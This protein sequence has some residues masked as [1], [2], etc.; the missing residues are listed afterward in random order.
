MKKKAKGSITVFLSLIMLLI[1]S[2]VCTVIEISRISSAYAR[3]NEI[4][5]MA[6][7]STFSSYARE[8]F[9]DYGIMVLWKNDTQLLND[10]TKYVDK[11]SNYKKDFKYNIYDILG[12][13]NANSKV[14]TVKNVMDNGGEIIYDQ[15]CDYM[16]NAIAQD[17]IDKLMK[18]SNALS[19]NE[20]IEQ[21][22]KSLEVCSDKLKD[23]EVNVK[24]IFDD[25]N[26]I[27]QCPYNPK[28]VIQNMKDRLNE[29]KSIEPTDDYNRQVRD[30]LFDMYIIEYRKY[31]EWKNTLDNYLQDILINSDKYFENL[32]LAKDYVDDMDTK[33]AKEKANYQNE[34]YSIMK[35]EITDLKQEVFNSDKDNY[36]IENNKKLTLE[37]K[38]IVDEISNSMSP[39]LE[40]TDELDYSYNKLSNYENADILIEDSYKAIYLAEEKIINYNFNLSVNYS[41]GDAT[42]KK[43]EVVDFVKKLKKDGV[44][45]YVVNGDISDKT[46]DKGKLSSDTY[47]DTEY[48][49]K[50][51]GRDKELLR[52]ILVGQYIFDKFNDYISGEK[53][54]QLNY[55]IEYILFG[56]GCDRDNLKE[57][58]NKIILLREGFNFLFLLKDSTKR[59]EAYELALTI[60]GY[61][62]MP[63]IVRLTQF[64]IMAAW[65]YAESVVDAKNLLEGEKVSLIK[66]ADEWN[67][68]LSNIKSL[69]S[70]NNK[71]KVES[72][73]TYE[74]YLRY[75]LIS[76]DKYTQVI[77]MLD[78]MELNIQ[79]KYNV[80]FQMKQCIVQATVYT[81]YKVKR[82]FSDIGFTRQII[83]GKEDEF[84]VKV[85]QTSGY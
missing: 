15:I 75:L 54:N 36:N 28:E 73:L 14:E 19:Q 9:E 85:K 68:S 41:I 46:I 83:R 50:N 23:M 7:D 71:N 58:I 47:K 17:V 27:K 62:G 59:N 35:E 20:D 51:Y 72:G 81:E 38:E 21:F 74:D 26:T 18:N 25:I 64:L 70:D 45:G 69:K 37:Q 40:R 57:C 31:K 3:C 6:L 8:I 42:K 44:M 1:F 34:L 11:N 2:L 63:A 4:T 52:K 61:T 65:S 82:L 24:N 30:N 78:L 48:K 56:N 29:I 49:W 5:Y 67:L 43:N 22:N 53:K 80:N 39:V 12:V 60:V 66:K 10:Y 84:I 76:Q 13:R 77:R 16:K 79:D 55:E 33:L 32:E